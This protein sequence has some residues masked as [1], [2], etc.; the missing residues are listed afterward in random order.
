MIQ[1]RRVCWQRELGD[2]QLVKRVRR[3][4]DAAVTAVV[5]FKLAGDVK[6]KIIY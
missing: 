5:A 6:G 4:T 3:A 2:R 1:E